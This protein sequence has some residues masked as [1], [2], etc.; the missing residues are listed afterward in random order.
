[1]TWLVTGASG[2][3]GRCFQEVQ[4]RLPFRNYKFLS[5]KELDITSGKS[6][7]ELSWKQYR[8]V[9][10][11]AAYTHVDQAETDRHTAYAVNVEGPGM[12]AEFCRKYDLPMIHISTDY[13][14]GPA[15]HPITEDHE[16]APAN[17]YG[18]TKWEGEQV[19]RSALDQHLIVRTSWLYAHLGHNFVRTMIRL[20]RDHEVIRVVDDQV[21]SPTYAT[22]LANALDDILHQEEDLKNMKWGT[23]NFSNKGAI[24]WFEFAR[25]ILHDKPAVTVLPISTDQYPVAANRSS[26]SV[27]DTSLFSETFDIEIRDWRASLRDCLEVLNAGD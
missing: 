24:S 14:Y 25:S 7:S 4:N 12:L 27:L 17:Y 2:Q 6:L 9:I 16:I 22:D 18:E 13:V 11:C 15:N 5:R 1:M 8:G 20:S 23:Y 3:L 26:Y 21:G 10:N 19:V